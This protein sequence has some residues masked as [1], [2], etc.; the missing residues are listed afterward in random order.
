MADEAV[1]VFLG[2]VIGVPVGVVLGWVAAQ[3]V[4]P[5]SDTVVLERTDH[6]YI[7]HEKG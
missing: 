5:H 1:W 7:I 4:I 3:M 6:G 2:V